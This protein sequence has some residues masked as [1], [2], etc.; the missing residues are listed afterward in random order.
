MSWVEP[1]PGQKKWMKEAVKLISEHDMT[2]A[3]M[4]QVGTSNEIKSFTLVC[5]NP[6]FTSEKKTCKSSLN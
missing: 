1:F 3:C 4:Y 5:S 2:A 6:P